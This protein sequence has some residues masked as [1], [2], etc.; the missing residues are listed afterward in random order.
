[1]HAPLLARA[2]AQWDTHSKPTVVLQANPEVEL[3]I[4][5]PVT[6]PTSY[7]DNPH[8]NW[9][10]STITSLHTQPQPI[11]PPCRFV[12]NNRDI[13]APTGYI[14]SLSRP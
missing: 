14:C 13:M 8:L 3:W 12:T 5:T 2:A 1:M 9:L 4:L 11:C 10:M 6:T 7:I